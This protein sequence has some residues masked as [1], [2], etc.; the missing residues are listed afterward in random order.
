M[1]L[2]QRAAKLLLSPS[3]NGILIDTDKESFAYDAHEIDRF[4]KKR[5]KMD[6]QYRGI[7]ESRVMFSKVSPDTRK[8]WSI[9]QDPTQG[10]I[11]GQFA[12]AEEGIL[13]G[14]I[15]FNNGHFYVWDAYQAEH[16]AV[17]ND[18]LR[19]HI[20][21][22]L[23]IELELSD[24]GSVEVI[25]PTV[26]R[27]EMDDYV[28]DCRNNAAFTRALP[29]AEF[30][31]LYE[32]VVE[33]ILNE[34]GEICVINPRVI[35][36]VNAE[37]I[38]FRE[39]R[40]PIHLKKIF[41]VHQNRDDIDLIVDPSRAEFSGL[42]KNCK[43]AR[44]LCVRDDKQVEHLVMWDGHHA[45]HFPVAHY[46]REEWGW[47]N[48]Y[49]FE[50][51]TPDDLSSYFQ[52]VGPYTY[53]GPDS[54]FE[55]PLGRWIKSTKESRVVED[56]LNEVTPRLRVTDKMRNS[57]RGNNSQV[58][59]E[60]PPEDFLKLTTGKMVDVDQIGSEAKS[61]VQYNRYTKAGHSD[62]YRDF[63]NRGKT[64]A[65]QDY[66]W[67]SSQ[68][69]MLV[70]E[71]SEQGGKIIGRVST[72][73]GRH[74]AAAYM[75]KGGKAYPV[76]IQLRGDIRVPGSPNYDSSKWWYN[77]DY[78]PGMVKSQYSEEWVN[79]SHWK[80]TAD[81]PLR[82]VQEGVDRIDAAIK[83]VASRHDGFSGN[84]GDFAYALKTALGSGDYLAADSG[85]HYEYVDHIALR[86]RGKI[87]DGSGLISAGELKRYGEITDYGSDDSV[88]HMVD[89]GS[90]GATLDIPQLVKE[91][92]QALIPITEKFVNGEI[93]YWKNPGKQELLGA[94]QRYHELRGIISKENVFFWPAENVTHGQG[95]NYLQTQG[96]IVGERKVVFAFASDQPACH[97]DPVW[98]QRLQHGQTGP[99][100]LATSS[101]GF[102]PGNPHEEYNAP[103]GA[104]I[105]TLKGNSINEVNLVNLNWA[106]KLS[107]SLPNDQQKRYKQ[108][109]EDAVEY[110]EHGVRVGIIKVDWNDPDATSKELG[111]RDMGNSDGNAYRMIAIMRGKNII[112]L[113]N[114][115]IPR[116]LH[117]RYWTINTPRIKPAY[118]G[119]GL[120]ILFYEYA[121]KHKKMNIVSHDQQ[122]PGSKMIWSVLAQKPDYQVVARD[123]S[124][125]EYP[126]L[127]QG[128]DILAHGE[129]VYAN[130]Q[131]EFLVCR[132]GINE[133]F[134]PETP[135]D[136]KDFVDLL[137]SQL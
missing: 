54:F 104:L 55:T 80:V 3:A 46:I 133:E 75:K 24:T 92:T 60:M 95:W 111:L 31:V 69:P 128:G 135:N 26:H 50:I 42:M 87:Y 10:Q 82:R 51:G 47:T 57:A 107:T 15:E 62:K 112:G 134:E 85:D 6:D 124:E 5:F 45:T 71:I 96:E 136:V 59:V 19:G 94:L 12:R 34:P 100:W 84:C 115:E 131:I 97:A 41:G 81:Q 79:T 118:R 120:G 13:R 65:D 21:T 36:M 17:I 88:R 125:Q 18:L 25:V 72:H 8:R 27:N 90:L 63:L 114:I 78:L 126:V 106:K 108:T 2:I 40:E 52:R 89:P 109:L 86:Y 129:S 16:D 117:G 119:K 103:W 93:P 76:A 28:S 32:N 68:H 48:W 113:A 101:M 53:A 23:P 20:H 132:A 1:W 29:N 110:P 98:S 91:L 105:R 44:G 74:R 22:G 38:P 99:I 49:Q 123:W 43:V 61:L 70:I 39:S 73:E 64:K 7:S 121:I 66:T 122:T 58:M 33:D 67:G 4:L 77:K 130:D 35:K 137:G 116:A 127:V 102:A 83:S 30:K 9:I 11:K 14:W 56:I 37:R